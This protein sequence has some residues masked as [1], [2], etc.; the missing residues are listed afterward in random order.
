MSVPNPGHPDS[1][2]WETHGERTL[3][4][5]P[6]VRLTLVDVQPPG[7][8][9]RFEHHVVR[10]FPV[11]VAVV[12]DDED[13]VLMMW[14][15]RFV[16]DAWGWELPGGIVEAGEPGATTA[17]RETEEETG[18]RPRDARHLV[19]FQPMMGMV[20]SPHEIYLSHGADFTGEPAVSEE[21]AQVAWIPLREVPELLSRGELLGSG[22]L[23]GLL[24][25]LAL[26]QSP[27]GFQR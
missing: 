13:R 5:S 14:R 8:G 6:W 11:A 7:G 10:L 4:D 20:D 9:K 22:T 25:V 27:S 3:Y 15:H 19:T 18:W 1:M 24:H 26:H 2:R 12:L 16:G 23:V 17:M 21:A